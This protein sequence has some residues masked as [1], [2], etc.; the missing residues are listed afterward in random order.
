M[1][2]QFLIPDPGNA[3]VSRE[4]GAVAVA[5]PA[6]KRVYVGDKLSQEGKLSYR[7]LLATQEPTR[8][9]PTGIYVLGQSAKADR[10]KE[11]EP[12]GRSR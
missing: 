5:F 7:V 10:P 12:D 11:G 6:I 8:E 3:V 2:S 1:V 4:E 9:N